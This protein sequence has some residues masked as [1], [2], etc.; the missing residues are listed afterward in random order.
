MKKCK[1]IKKQLDCDTTRLC[2]WSKRDSDKKNK[3]NLFDDLNKEEKN[4]F[5]RQ[6]RNRLSKSREKEIVDKK[7]TTATKKKKKV[8]EPV[9]KKQSKEGVIKKTRKV[10]ADTEKFAEKVRVL[11]APSPHRKVVADAEIL[12]EKVRILNLAKEAVKRILEMKHSNHILSEVNAE[13]IIVA[14]FVQTILA[15]K[16]KTSENLR[17]IKTAKEEFNEIIK[18][19]SFDQIKK[20]KKLYPTLF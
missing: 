12:A 11:K 20:A 13:T 14:R 4:L 17:A 10:V 5:R 3:C 7:K 15:S 9:G 16:H 6:K 19:S 8:M 1:S 2:L 18:K